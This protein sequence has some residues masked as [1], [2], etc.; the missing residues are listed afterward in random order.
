MPKILILFIIFL[1]VYRLKLSRIKSNHKDNVEQFMQKELEASKVRKTPM[2]DLPVLTIDI[3]HLPLWKNAPTD[4]KK[5]PIWEAQQRV[6]EAAVLPM[7]NL[8]DQSNIELKL[9]YGPANLEILTNYESNF[10]RFTQ[11]L[12]EWSKSLQNAGHE[13]EAISILEYA[14]DMDTDLSQIYRLLGDL[15]KQKKQPQKLKSLQEKAA[16]FSSP[17]MINITTYL[18]SLLE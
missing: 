15:Y 12:F 16:Q 3:D 2:E 13:K 11:S 9:Q 6:L 10:V 1:V 17:T 4:S 5:Q 14:V 7:S 18:S 8:A